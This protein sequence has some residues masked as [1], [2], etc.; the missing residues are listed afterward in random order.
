MAEAADESALQA[1]LL[2]RSKGPAGW[3]T[4]LQVDRLAYARAM[5]RRLAAGASIELMRGEVSRLRTVRSGSASKIAGVRAEDG[6]VVEAGAVI[7]T[8]GTFLSAR[9]HVGRSQTVGGRAGDRSS[10][11]LSRQLRELGLETG[12]FK[13]GT[14]PRLVGSSI[15]W[16][17]CEEQPSEAGVGPLSMRTDPTAFPRLA[18]RST[19]VTRTSPG[20]HAIVRAALELPRSRPA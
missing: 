12:R 20:T 9:M 13:T 15:D 19:Y 4:R 18:Q 10:E 7:L 1:R 16:A 17:L 14:P 2:N 8:T 6:S 3:A 5:Q 11:G